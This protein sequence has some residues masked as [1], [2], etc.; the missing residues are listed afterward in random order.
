MIKQIAAYLGGIVLTSL[1]IF[2]SFKK[3]DK[4]ILTVSPEILS[5][6][7]NPKKQHLKFY[8]KQKNDSNYFNFK[9]LK[10]ELQKENKQLLFAT[11]GGMYN[12]DSSPKGLYVEDFKVLSGIDKKIKD[13]GNF[14]CTLMVPFI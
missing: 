9:Q 4:T 8:W 7:V 5:Y 12:K 2:Y 3:E 11:N 6:I 13:Y 1:I 14:F 10:T